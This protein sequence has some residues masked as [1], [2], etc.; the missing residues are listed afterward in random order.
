MRC[1]LCSLGTDLWSQRRV[2]SQARKMAFDEANGKRTETVAV[3]CVQELVGKVGP[4]IV[5]ET[6]IEE[7]LKEL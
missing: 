5:G 1:V 4:E 2:A 3:A 6:T 7:A